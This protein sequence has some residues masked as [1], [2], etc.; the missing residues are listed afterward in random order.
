MKKTAV[1][2]VLIC[3]LA[4]TIPLQYLVRREVVVGLPSDSAHSHAH[5]EEDEHAHEGEGEEEEHA[6]EH[7]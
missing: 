6:Q 5:V 1:L 3:L 4:A 2:A 7:T